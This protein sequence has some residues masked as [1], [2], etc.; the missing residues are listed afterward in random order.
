MEQAPLSM[1]FLSQDWCPGLCAV[2]ASG[3]GGPVRAEG[4][5]GGQENLSWKPKQGFNSRGMKL[6]GSERDQGR[7][8]LWV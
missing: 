5:S 2:A 7:V 6:R 1:G 4:A 8:R 3:P